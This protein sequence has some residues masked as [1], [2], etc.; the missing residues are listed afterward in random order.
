MEEQQVAKHGMQEDRELRSGSTPH[1]TS[2]TF[3]K[4]V[5][6][7]LN[8]Y[9]TVAEAKA[10][11]LLAADVMVLQFLLKDL[12]HPAAGL[13]FH[14]AAASLLVASAVASLSVVYPRLPHAHTSAVFWE[15]IRASKSPDA[16]FSRVSVLDHS[17]EEEQYAYQNYY[18]SGVLHRKMRWIQWAIW[19]FG[20]GGA[21]TLICVIW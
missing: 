3:G 18:V 5:N 16:Y 21:C 13:P 20:L 12:F 4:G 6:D 19:L 2:G 8:L 10:A 15:A 9:V 7:Y 1:H 11:A 17:D 14:I